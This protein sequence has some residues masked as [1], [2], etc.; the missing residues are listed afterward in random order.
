MR[1][2]DEQKQAVIAEMRADDA[3]EC[4]TC[5]SAVVSEPYLTNKHEGFQYRCRECGG[6]A[7]DLKLSE[8]F[9]RRTAGN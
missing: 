8:S 9:L 2:T 7:A 3:A 4:P 6:T 1:W 5:G